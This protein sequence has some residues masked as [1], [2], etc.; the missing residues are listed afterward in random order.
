MCCILFNAIVALGFNYVHGAILMA[1]THAN[2][3]E[4]TQE[5]LSAK[6]KGEPS[7]LLVDR[8]SSA[9]A[10]LA[11]Q[12]YINNSPVVQGKTIQRQV[13]GWNKKELGSG[14]QIYHNTD[15]SSVQSII[16]NHIQQVTN[17]F[18]GGQLGSGF[19]TY[20]EK[21]SADLFGGA[22]TLEFSLTSDATGQEV[23][24]DA[25]WDAFSTHAADALVG[26]DF[27]WTDEDVNQYK[28][29]SGDKLKLEAVHDLNAKQTFS[30]DEYKDILGI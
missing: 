24:N 21:D 4:G 9:A 16:E 15:L 17:A 3:T 1:Y 26:N 25:T 23:P 29:H 19:Y 10:Q 20:T 11:T 5:A 6:T 8:R 7:A 28:F 12:S 13:Q 22:V 18:G 30:V 27:L 14:Q 2:K